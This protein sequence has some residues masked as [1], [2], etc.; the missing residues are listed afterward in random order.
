[1]KQHEYVAAYV[2]GGVLRAVSGVHKDTPAEALASA[3]PQEGE[4]V[5]VFRRAVGPWRELNEQE[6]KQLKGDK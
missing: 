2:K 5:R 3:Q 4:T 6:R 1:M